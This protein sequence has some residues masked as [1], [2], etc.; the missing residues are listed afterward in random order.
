MAAA[1]NRIVIIGGE[2]KERVIVVGLNVRVGIAVPH[3]FY[4]VVLLK[5]S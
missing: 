1:V 4:F 3:Y 2:G 5:L